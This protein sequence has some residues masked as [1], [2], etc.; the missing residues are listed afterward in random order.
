MR[1]VADKRKENQNTIFCSIFFSLKK[2]CRLLDNAEKYCRAG[3]VTDDNMAHA[4][5]ILDT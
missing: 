3:Q 5:C 2:S 4:H 1:I